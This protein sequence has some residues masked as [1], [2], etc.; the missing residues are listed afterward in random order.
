MPILEDD[1]SPFLSL[2]S[3]IESLESIIE[4]PDDLYSLD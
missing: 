3:L 2:N 4:T 1:W